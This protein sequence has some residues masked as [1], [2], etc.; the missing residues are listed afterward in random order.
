MGRKSR[1]LMLT[2][3]VEALPKRA[4]DDHVRRLMWGEQPGGRAGVR[5]IS[6]LG[7]EFDLTHTF[8][9]DYCGAFARKP[10]I[11]EVVKWLVQAGEDVQLHTHP[12]YLPAEFWAEHG[13]EANPRM[14]NEY[15]SEKAAF[16]MKY[17]SDLLA[18]AKGEPVLGFRAGS[19]RWNAGM[20]EALAKAGIRLSS[21]NSVISRNQGKCVY[22]EPT[23]YPFQWSNGVLEAPMTEKQFFP[24]FHKALWGRMQY[25]FSEHFNKPFMRLLRPLGAGGQG[26]FQVMLLHSWSLLYWDENDYATYRDGQR[27]EGYRKLLKKVAKDYDVITVPEFLDLQARGAFGDLKTVDVELAALKA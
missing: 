22:S 2:V 19:F 18:Q 4:S 20:L 27:I 10:E 16:A 1:Y 11:D 3:D 6:A 23:C 5:E 21:N 25:P 13:F 15:S 17:F 12:E 8:Y 14:P 7:K 9:V 26:S 24:A